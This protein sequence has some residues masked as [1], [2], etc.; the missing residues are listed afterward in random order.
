MLALD[1]QEVVWERTGQVNPQTAIGEP[2]RFAGDID[3][4]GFDD[5]V[6]LGY[7][8]P[9]WTQELLFLSGRDGSTLRTQ[10]L[11]PGNQTFFD[12]YGPAGDLN[13]DVVPDYVYAA[14]E[15]GS[16]W[17]DYLWAH[18]GRDGTVIWSLRNPSRFYVAPATA[19]LGG[20]DLN[21]DGRPDIVALWRTGRGGMVGAF[22]HSGQTL[23]RHVGTNLTFEVGSGHRGNS[24]GWV[25]DVD[26]DS[27]ADFV[28]G[29]FDHSIGRYV[30]VVLSGRTGLQRRTGLGVIPHESIGFSV[31][32]C[33]D[34]DG[35]G[36][37]DFAGSSGG[38]LGEQGQAHVFSGRDGS[39]LRSWLGVQAART[40]RSGG[41]DLDRDGIPDVILFRGEGSVGAGIGGAYVC[42]GRDSS[43]ILR[44]LD[45]PTTTGTSRSCAYLN[46]DTS[47]ID[48]GR[49][50]PGNPS[51][52]FVINEPEYGLTGSDYLG[53]IRLYRGTPPGVESFG[54]RCSGTLRSAPQIG[55]R[56]LQGFGV[57]IHLSS[58]PAGAPA[59]LLLGFSSSQWHGLTLPLSLASLGL[60]Q[61][62]LY[63]SVE[64]IAT[65]A[66]GL[67]GLERGYA[68]IDLPWP[69]KAPAQALFVLHGQWIVL[70]PTRAGIGL[71]EAMTWRH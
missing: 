44:V 8:M 18:S 32:G 33:G 28:L 15:N 30:T 19:V 13:G 27:T 54:A 51:P 62:F 52:V 7:R 34:I 63:T 46:H 25:G 67:S 23:Y 50:Q 53:R 43:W 61:C 65:T 14:F 37:P 64:L 40:L 55:L 3:G 47:T 57:R 20:Q 38:W 49:P 31:D 41:H 42:S 45:C 60:P 11:P 21:G 10:Q 39:V 69:L 66:S 4:D 56:D 5:L 22:D 70:D 36:V 71:S 35:D 16:P 26:D 58:A 48:V 9:R 17:L 68:S 24:L 2:A 59:A 29:S 6:T 1:A 12:G